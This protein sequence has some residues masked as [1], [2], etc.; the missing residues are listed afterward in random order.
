MNGKH[1]FSKKLVLAAALGLVALAPMHALAANKLIVNGTDGVTPKF[2]VTDTGY[3]GVGTNAP[4]APITLKSVGLFPANVIKVVGD[5]TTKGA[6]LIGYSNRA[7][8]TTLSRANDRLGFVFFGSNTGGTLQHPAGFAGV[9]EADWTASSWPAYFA[10]QTTAPGSTTRTKRLR[11]TGSGK[12]GI[13]TTAPTSMLHV[14]GLPV[15][16]NNADAIAG[17]LTAG[18]F[19]RTGGDPDLVCVVH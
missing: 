9:A 4:D 11:I 2:V 14:V 5:E 1:Q 12:V 17:G 18:A 8:G 19:Y 3:I 6:G 16:A 15:F 13:G 10:F 7:D